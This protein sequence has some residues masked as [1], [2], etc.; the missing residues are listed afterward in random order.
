MNRP[1]QKDEALLR[2]RARGQ[3]FQE[4]IE[5]AVQRYRPIDFAP[6]AAL[7]LRDV[8][9]KSD[10]MAQWPPHFLVRAIEANC[11]YHNVHRAD[12]V[13][14]RALAKVLREYHTYQDPLT[15]YLLDEA[16]NLGE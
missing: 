10:R 7:K 2:A 15:D 4:A 14:E 12:P 8:L 3:R 6:V 16:R 9:G 5:A 11:A 13:T 1:T